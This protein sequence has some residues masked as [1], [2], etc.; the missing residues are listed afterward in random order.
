[1]FKLQD[2]L[3]GARGVLASCYI[4]IDRVCGVNNI[5]VPLY[6]TEAYGAMNLDQEVV[7]LSVTC[8]HRR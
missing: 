4:Y 1:M 5:R 2:I 6:L 8:C 3:H 7:G